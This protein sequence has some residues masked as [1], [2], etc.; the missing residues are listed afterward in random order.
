MGSNPSL[1]SGNITNMVGTQQYHV[2]WF[3]YDLQNNQLITTKYVPGDISDS[4]E[5]VFVETP[6]PGL[7]YRPISPGGAGNR[8]VAFQIPLVYRTAAVGAV[9]MIKLLDTVRNRSSVSLLGKRGFQFDSNPRVLYNWGVASI[10]LVYYVTKCDM[11]H[12]AGW[13]NAFGQPQYSEI[14]IELT[15]DESNVL[16]QGEELY[17]AVNALLGMAQGLLQ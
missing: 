2:P 11:T 12:K 15:L 17:R 6:V 9:P 4:K 5:I 13:V 8:K 3:M 10:P 16:Y 7:N 14:D 1:L